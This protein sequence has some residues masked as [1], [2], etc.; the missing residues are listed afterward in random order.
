M[1]NE[2][3]IQKKNKIRNITRKNDCAALRK[4]NWQEV[5]NLIMYNCGLNVRINAWKSL[6]PNPMQLLHNSVLSDMKIKERCIRFHWKFGKWLT[7]KLE[8]NEH[9]YMYNMQALLKILTTFEDHNLQKCCYMQS[10]I[11]V[12]YFYVSLMEKSARTC[13]NIWP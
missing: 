3:K 7:L 8:W 1:Q 6:F 12:D 2:E 10:T 13:T 9:A 5:N 4:K 11:W